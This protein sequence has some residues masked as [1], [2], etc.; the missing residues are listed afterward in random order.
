MQST[1]EGAA[2]AREAARPLLECR[3]VEVVYNHVQ[4]AIQG[5]SIEVPDG[6]IV[7]VLGPNGAGK[8]TLLRAITGFLPAENGEITDGEVRFDGQR[9][10]GLPPDEI[11]RRGVCIVPE[12]ESIFRS[13]PV[14]DN[15]RIVPHPGDEASRAGAM[16]RIHELFPVLEERRKQVA[17]YMSGGERKMLAIARALLLAPRVLLVDEL[18]F[19]LAPVIVTRLMGILSAIN[20]EQG[21]SIVLVEQNA[22]SALRIAHY[23]Y[24]IETGR[25]V[26]DGTPDMLRGNADVQRFYLGISDEAGIRSYADVKHYRR[27]RRW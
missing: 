24:I 4:V 13:L 17:G 18:S 2:A 7:A 5:L 9:I 21:T 12:E 27:K 10:S 15:L 8:T 26:F 16:A 20:R 6:S 11:A 23:A 1:E 14:E 3:Q 19:G 25:V 22:A